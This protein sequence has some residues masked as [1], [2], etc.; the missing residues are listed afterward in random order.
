MTTLCSMCGRPIHL[1]RTK[2]KDG[3][4]CGG[5]VDRLTPNM[6]AS[7][8]MHTG[9]ELEAMIR[10]IEQRADARKHT[11]VP[12]PVELPFDIRK[13]PER[14]PEPDRFEQVRQYKAL[15]DE[16][17]ITEEEFERKRKELL[18]L[19][20]DNDESSS[21]MVAGVA[22]AQEAVWSPPSPST[23]TLEPKARPIVSNL[24]LVTVAWT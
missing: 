9:P 24:D 13:G 22:P 3:Y 19:R 21:V 18:E 14:G 2:V 7:K 23:S 8:E 1:I 5:C 10:P 4:I 20:D 6:Y 11:S 15:L 12:V 16:G 17:I